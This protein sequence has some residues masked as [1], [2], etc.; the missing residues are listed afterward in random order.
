MIS[1]YVQVGGN[2]LLCESCD[3]ESFGGYCEL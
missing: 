2:W 1:S 3:C